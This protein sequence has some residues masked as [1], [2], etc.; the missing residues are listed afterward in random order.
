MKSWEKKFFDQLKNAGFDEQLARKVNC[1]V[2]E[3]VVKLV[4]NGG[5]FVEDIISQ[6]RAREIM[7]KNFFGVEEAVKYFKVK[8]TPQQIAA[9]VPFS[10]AVLEKH[11]NSHILVATFPLSILQIR[12]ITTQKK[13]KL[14]HSEGA[15]WYVDEGFALKPGRFSWQLISKNPVPKSNCKTWDEQLELLKNKECA[16]SAK[17]IVYAIIGYYLTTREALFENI[18]VR[19]GS[20][21]SS[22]Y[23][24]SVG[25]FPRH[26]EPGIQI[27]GFFDSERS[28]DIFLCV[29]RRKEIL[30]LY[31]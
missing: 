24:V 13:L 5:F 8:P 6:A 1:R 19:T 20:S 31:C 4:R 25:F 10:E 2:A 27:C 3:S 28:K 23:Q 29:A 12:E 9:G 30:D 15:A 16:P 7:G 11:K 21:Y 17:D 18:Y 26:E 22:T 14:F